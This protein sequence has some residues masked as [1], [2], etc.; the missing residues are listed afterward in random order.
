[1][2]SFKPYYQIISCFFF[3]LLGFQIKLELESSSIENIVFFRSLWGVIFLIIIFFISRKTFSFKNY[4]FDNINIHFLRAIFGVLAMYFGYNSLNHLTLA[5]ASTI[6]Y[7]KIFFTTILALIFFRENV[8]PIN[9]V[10]I[11][12]GFSGIF[13]ISNPKAI[14]NNIGIYMSLFSALCVSGGILSISYLSKKEDTKNIL[15]NHSFFSTIIF[16][17]LFKEKIDLSLFLDHFNFLLITLTALAGQ[18]FNTESF[19][20]SPTN[21]VIIL[22]YSRIIFSTGLGF[23]FLNETISLQNFIGIILITLT[24]FSVKRKNT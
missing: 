10:Y 18:Y 15:L 19:K 8:K 21:E 11:F 20:S 9:I 4:N 1:M 13:L 22:S 6:G 23:F 14:D 17:L 12:V 16:Y 5:Q 2:K 3:S 7:T 24:T